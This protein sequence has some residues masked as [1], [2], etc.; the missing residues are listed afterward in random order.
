MATRREDI[1]IE[2]GRILEGSK[3]FK[4]V[5][6]NITPIWTQVKQVPAASYLYTTEDV[7]VSSGDRLRGK[8]KLMIYITNKQKHSDDFEDILSTLITQVEFLI[9]RNE[10]LKCNTIETLVTNIKQDGGILHPYAVAQ[11]TVTI[12]YLKLMEA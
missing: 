5:Y 7:E 3:L 9:D 12:D 6:K 2:V 10:F 4:K 8:L 1:L 11:L